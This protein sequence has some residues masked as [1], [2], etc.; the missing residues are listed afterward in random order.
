VLWALLTH[1]QSYSDPAA[2]L[3][4]ELGLIT[5]TVGELICVSWAAVTAEPIAQLARHY[6]NK[7]ATVDGVARMFRP[8]LTVNVGAGTRFRFFACR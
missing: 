3:R 6:L 1:N 5:A 8:K 7:R 4:T 2:A